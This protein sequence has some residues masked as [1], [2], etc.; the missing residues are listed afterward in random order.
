MAISSGSRVVNQ[1]LGVAIPTLAAGILVGF[2]PGSSLTGFLLLLAGLAV[3]KGTFR[4]IEQFTGHA[5]AFRLLAR[6]RADTYK[7]IVPLAP[8]GL[9]EDRTGDLV[10]RVIGDIDRVEPFYAHTIAPLISA[11]AVPALAAIGI[12]VWID[13]FLAA[14]FI[15]FPLLMASVTPWIRARRVARASQGARAQSGETAAFFTDAV[16]GARE[17]AIFDAGEIISTRIETRSTDNTLTLRSLSHIAAFRVGLGDLL[18]A[19]AVVV[20][21][22]AA[23]GRFGAGLIG[24]PEFAAAI[25]ISWVGA[26]P[27]RAVEEIVPDLEQ[28]LAA[29]GRLYELADRKPPVQRSAGTEIPDDGTVT[30]EGVSVM[31][32]TAETP[33]LTEVDVVIRD[34]SFVA[35]VGPSGSGKSTLVEL[36]VRFRDPDVG[37]VTLGGADLSAVEQSLLTE[38]VTLVPQRSEIFHGTLADNL[39]LARPTATR[40]ELGDAL[41]RAQLGAW[42]DSLDN[43]LETKVGELGSTLS[44]G[45]RQR[46]AIARA[47]LRDPKV[48]V[49]DEA[50]SELDGLTER[51]VLNEIARER[52]KRTLMVV[53]HRVASIIAADE[54][55]VVDAGRIVERG[56]HESLLA[57]GGVYSGIWRRHLD[58]VPGS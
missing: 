58:L 56:T 40:A 4:Y 32:H 38:A 24:I 26:A 29:A 44:G 3:V 13:P 39:L 2:G 25:V 9:E 43:G 17:I 34:K 51:L 45:Q 48:L 7:R 22:V 36:L 46:L 47:F 20:M 19:G 37:R 35:I 23:A 16:Q 14:V 52:G 11:L 54:I 53:A 8:A 42:V 1:G 21:M 12:A 30:Y 49:L 18:A 50:T 28:A 10:N 57:A 55:L 15:P 41:D 27:A 31:F 33:S 5:V 6:L